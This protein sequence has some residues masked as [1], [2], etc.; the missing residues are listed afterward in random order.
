MRR[1]N[2]SGCEVR[3]VIETRVELDLVYHREYCSE[4]SGVICVGMSKS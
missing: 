4:L 3:Y 1:V 2:I